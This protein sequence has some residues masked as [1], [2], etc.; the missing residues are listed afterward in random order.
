M[1]VPAAAEVLHLSAPLL[2]EPSVV[3]GLVVVALLLLMLTT[4]LGLGCVV[5][6]SSTAVEALR[7]SKLFRTPRVEL[8][9]P[10]VPIVSRAKASSALE[11]AASRSAATLRKSCNILLRGPGL[12]RLKDV[13]VAIGVQRHL[14]IVGPRRGLHLVK[15][16]VEDTQVLL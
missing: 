7:G 6:L 2:T 16:P 9:V 13:V 5:E 10:G 4:A 3:V 12:G 1:L 11:T 8:L 14:L 15:R